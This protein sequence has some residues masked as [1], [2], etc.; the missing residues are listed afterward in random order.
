MNWMTA[1]GSS[2]RRCHHGSPDCEGVVANE[3]PDRVRRT[4]GVSS[5]AS[6]PLRNLKVSKFQAKRKQSQ[7]ECRNAAGGA[8]RIL[9]PRKRPTTMLGR[10]LDNKVAR[11]RGAVRQVNVDPPRQKKKCPLDHSAITADHRS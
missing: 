3:V 6:M 1:D 7:T 2:S 9:G 4:L 10:R 8:L 11:S 5:V